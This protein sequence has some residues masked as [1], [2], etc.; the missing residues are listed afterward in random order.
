MYISKFIF[1]SLTINNKKK[2][3]TKGNAI[4]LA[5]MSSFQMAQ[6]SS[7]CYN[8]CNE[9]LNMF[10]TLINYLLSEKSENK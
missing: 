10:M 4:T 6:Y 5:I 2:T 9:K 1:S 3:K 7:E 8:P